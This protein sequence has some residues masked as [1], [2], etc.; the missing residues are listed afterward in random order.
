MPHL[1]GIDIGT[2]GAKVVLIDADGRIV[3]LGA[4]DYPIAQPRP[5][6]AEQNP[7]DWWRAACV[8]VR[9]ALQQ[10]RNARDR[11]VAIGI[12]G[13]MHGMVL[14]D[15]HGD[16]VRPAII[17]P[18]QRSHAEVERA[19]GALG[20]ERLGRLAANRL[21]VGFMAA[22]LMWL[23]RHEA[24]ALASTDKVVLPKDYVRLQLTGQVASDV[25]DASAT[26]L[27]DV[28]GR[29][30][31]CE[32]LD[33]WQIP[34]RLLPPVLESAAVAG[35]LLPEAAQMLGLHAGIPVVVGAADQACQLVG[36]GLLDPGLASCTI[37]T[38]GSSSRPWLL[39]PMIRS[40]A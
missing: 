20:L 15:A 5:G 13:Q 35:A 14:L 39:R 40:C 38:G 12:S 30:W 18:D 2:S 25:S 9:A 7:A 31:S 28:A 29:R 8:S 27:F 34:D 3:G 26:L 36:S 10:T 24:E 32:L 11:V 16:P 19:C 4:Q 21:A 22:S 37:G 17:W 6:W 23:A 33:A 1:L